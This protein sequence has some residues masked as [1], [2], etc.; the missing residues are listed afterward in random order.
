MKRSYTTLIGLCLTT[1]SYIGFGQTSSL[2]SV[3]TNGSLTYSP[4]SDGNIIPDFSMVGYHNGEENLPEVPVKVTLHPS[5]G[6][7]HADIQYAIDSV[8]A[9]NPDA[10]GHRGAILLTQGTYEVSSTLTVNTSGVV[11]RGEG[12]GSNGTILKLTA[13]TQTNLLEIQGD[14][15]VVVNSATE[16]AVIGSVAVGEKTITVASGHSFQ[17]G[18]RVIL[19]SQLTQTYIET[20]G[21]DNLESE[22]GEGHIDWT[23][24]IYTIKYKRVVTNVNGNDI[25]L[26]APVVDPIT[27]INNPAVLMKYTWDDKIEECGVEYIRLESTYSSETDEAHGWRAILFNY[28]ENAWVKNVKAYYFGY[29]AVDMSKGSYKVTVQDCGMYEYKSIITGSRRY[30]FRLELGQLCL[31][32]NCSTT[33][34]R[35][36]YVSA[37]LAPGPNVFY[38]VVASNTHSDIGPHARWATGTLYDNA[39]TDTKLRVQNRTCSG[40]G[41]GWAGAQ[42][43]FWNCTANEI[44][45]QDPAAEQLNWAIGCTGTTTNTGQWKTEPLGFVESKNSPIEA[46]PSLYLAQLTDRLGPD[47]PSNLAFDNSTIGQVD[48]TWTDNSNSETG[49]IVERL[50]NGSWI[51]LATVSANATSYS[52]TGLPGLYN[53]SYRV[54]AKNVTALSVASNEI[55]ATASSGLLVVAEDSYIRDGN[56]AADNNDGE[57]LKIKKGGSG[58]N[59]ESFVKFDLSSLPAGIDNA[60]L[61]IEVT[62]SAA[63]N[64]FEAFIVTDDSWT[65]SGI[66]W[67]NAPS[68]SYSLGTATNT[69]SENTLS[70]DLSTEVL[71]ELAGDQ[72]LSIKIIGI[73]KGTMSFMESK[74]STTVTSEKPNITY[75]TTSTEIT[76]SD[77]AFVRRKN[78]VDVNYGTGLLNLKQGSTDDNNVTRRSILKFDLSGVSGTISNAKIRLTSAVAAANTIEA[79]FVSDDSWSESTVTYNNMPAYSTLISTQSIAANDAIIEF[80]VTSLAQTNGILS[81]YLKSTDVGTLSKFYDKDDATISNRPTLIINDPN[82]SARKG[83]EI[84]FEEASTTDFL[85][86]P[87]PV[88]DILYVEGSVDNS[89]FHIYNSV[90]NLQVTTSYN[91]GINLSELKSGLYIVKIQGETGTVIKK[92]IKE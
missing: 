33:E 43:M 55:T 89:D 57:Q 80:D 22:C 40:S 60:T 47:A 45:I 9:M 51:E 5:S 31:I 34:G 11:I 58:Y 2:V 38:N 85:L 75:E 12:E 66:T 91:N 21:L 20:L 64:T 30:G 52:D 44:V 62:G 92:I 46:I 8:S 16:K 27:D 14:T 32:K 56:Y 48:L 15:S 82:S 10:N 28:I 74:E 87:N 69:A 79:Y 84:S 19:Q 23:P 1:L 71:N 67:N 41:H 49:F 77:D 63:I 61:N 39:V 29:G 24:E 76:A 36:D 59:R 25:T 65:E 73:D 7:R 81:V 68:V 83:T 6:D 35:H 78:Y 3:D 53:Y 17:L 54:L 42:Q 70:W 72:T 13:T 50:V 26:D 4:D 90:G 86:F 18:D 88:Q 37:Y